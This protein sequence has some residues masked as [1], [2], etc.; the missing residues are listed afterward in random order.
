[1]AKEKIKKERKKLTKKKKITIGVVI[2]VVLLLLGANLLGLFHYTGGN[3]ELV[4]KKLDIK[5]KTLFSKIDTKK[6]DQAT[7]YMNAGSLKG[8]RIT[9]T[10]KKEEAS[11]NDAINTYFKSKNHYSDDFGGEY[12]TTDFTYS[13]T[14]HTKDNQQYTIWYYNN[15]TI[16]FEDKFYYV[17]PSIDNKGID[18]I[19]NKFNAGHAFEYYP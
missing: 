13:I 7:I 12:Q 16:R 17:S 15:Y 11:L 1:M 14:F 6:I 18:T 10:K 5:E 2:A 4:G 19:L 8:R 9:V 3:V